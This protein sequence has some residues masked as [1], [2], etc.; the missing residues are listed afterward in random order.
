MFRIRMCN[1][2]TVSMPD[3]SGTPRKSTPQK[4]LRPETLVAI[5]D[6]ETEDL[7]RGMRSAALPWCPALAGAGPTIPAR[8]AP[9]GG[10]LLRGRFLHRLL[11][12]LRLHRCLGHGLFLLSF[13]LSCSNQLELENLEQFQAIC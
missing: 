7:S 9:L 6:L 2:Q 8:S 10:A 5:S 3:R 1:K 13:S 11:L 4:C 12:C